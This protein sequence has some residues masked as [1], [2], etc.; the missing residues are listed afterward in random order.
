MQAQPAAR[1]CACRC[2]ACAAAAPHANHRPNA[3]C[4]FIAGVTPA[5]SAATQPHH[6]SSWL[7]PLGS[8]SLPV[9]IRESAAR[10]VAALAPQHTA[11]ARRLAVSQVRLLTQLLSHASGREEAL[12]NRIASPA[13]AALGEA[14]EQGDDVEAT[15][16]LEAL[17][18]TRIELLQYAN[19]LVRV[20]VARQV[21]SNSQAIQPPT[22]PYPVSQS[23]SMIHL[24]VHAL[25]RTREFVEA[26]HA[27]GAAAFA[28]GEP[29]SAAAPPP[30]ARGGI[31]ERQAFAGWAQGK[32]SK[33]QHSCQTC[34]TTHHSTSALCHIY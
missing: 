31:F 8:P 6:S 2:L 4:C 11:H 23:C 15:G 7:K 21:R 25:Q 24:T 10:A 29:T 5:P 34:G 22:Q 32:M 27:F 26:A 3:T 16:Q 12:A 20:G 17:V 13:E 33:M 30:S 14:V 9:D 28:L 1:P 19:A 18:A